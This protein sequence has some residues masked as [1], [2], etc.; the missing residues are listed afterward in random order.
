MLFSLISELWMG[1]IAGQQCHT[2]S[3]KQFVTS[4][5]CSIILWAHAHY[6]MI[7]MFVCKLTIGLEKLNLTKIVSML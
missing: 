4:S 3:A 5:A 1:G 2:V 7:E 6:A